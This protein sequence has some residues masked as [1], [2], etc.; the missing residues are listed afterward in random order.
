MPA[1]ACFRI[2]GTESRGNGHVPRVKRRPRGDGLHGSLPW[3][4]LRIPGKLRSQLGALVLQTPTRGG[5]GPRA[6]GLPYVQWAQH[7]SRCGRSTARPERSGFVKPPP[8][9]W[10]VLR[11]PRGFSPPSV[12]RPPSL[13]L[14][15][16]P[17]GL[18]DLTRTP[19]GD[20][21]G[22]PRASC[23]PLQGWEGTE[24]VTRPG[25]HSSLGSLGLRAE[26]DPG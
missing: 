14:S 7:H 22:R 4:A 17:G 15:C 13:V 11:C 20:E 19:A 26:P 3:T 21:C 10:H 2:R 24:S 25:A 9:A 16:R 5:K 8:G 1:V 6:S 12:F 18:S 23:S